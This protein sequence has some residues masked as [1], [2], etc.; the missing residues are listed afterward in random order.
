[1]LEQTYKRNG[2]CYILKVEKFQKVNS[3]AMKKTGYYLCEDE[4]ISIDTLE[5]FKLAK[6]KF[7]KNTKYL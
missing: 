4:M 7:D 3:L 1:M 5:E 6:K 2:V